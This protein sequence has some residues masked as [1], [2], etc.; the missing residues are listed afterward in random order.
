MTNEQFETI[1]SLQLMWFQAQVDVL[2]KILVRAGLCSEKGLESE[3]AEYAQQNAPR[4]AGYLRDDI[5]FYLKEIVQSGLSFEE[6]V[7]R[8]QA[9][10]DRWNSIQGGGEKSPEEGS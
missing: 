10:R 8:F 2:E 6:C 1:L 5:A 9:D 7:Q 3:V 4:I